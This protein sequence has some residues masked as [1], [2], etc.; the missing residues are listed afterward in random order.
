MMSQKS[1][2]TLLLVAA[3]GTFLLGIGPTITDLQDWHGA[4]TPEIVGKILMQL[5]SVILA[6]VGGKLLP[7]G[8]K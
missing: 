2:G 1:A 3:F 5:G 8:E 6:A 7:S 4:G